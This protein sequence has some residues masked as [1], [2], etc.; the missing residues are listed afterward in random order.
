MYYIAHFDVHKI[1]SVYKK[2]KIDSYSVL[3][4]GI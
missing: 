2:K 1:M 3:D 4:L